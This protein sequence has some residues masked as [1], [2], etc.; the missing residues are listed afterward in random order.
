MEKV[1]D[2][3]DYT[4]EFSVKMMELLD[5]SASGVASSGT[6]EIEMPHCINALLK[7]EDCFASEPVA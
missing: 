2:E 7:L 5:L 6:S 3:M 1:P 4:P